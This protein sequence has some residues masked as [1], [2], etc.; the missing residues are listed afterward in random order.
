MC[1]LTEAYVN[2]RLG[3]MSFLFPN[4]GRKPVSNEENLIVN[5]VTQILW[6]YVYEN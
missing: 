5:S 4:I 2:E 1:D 3:G 6:L